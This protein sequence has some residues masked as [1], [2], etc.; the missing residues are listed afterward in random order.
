MQGPVKLTLIWCQIP[1]EYLKL[2]LPAFLGEEVGSGLVFLRMGRMD[3][4]E[5]KSFP[6]C[7]GN[8]K[9]QKIA[10]KRHLYSGQITGILVAIPYLNFSTVF[11]KSPCFLPN[12]METWK[13]GQSVV[14]WP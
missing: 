7:W 10:Y 4:G 11:D 13:P 1:E 5:P 2:D 8:R 6:F 14:M 9:G 3:C 12:K